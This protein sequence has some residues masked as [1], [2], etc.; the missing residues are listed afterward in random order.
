VSTAHPGLVCGLVCALLCGSSIGCEATDGE[1]ESAVGR[2]RADDEAEANQADPDDEAPS[3][4]ESEEASTDAGDVDPDAEKPASSDAGEGASDEGQCWFE[5]LGDW[6]RCEEWGFPNAIEVP[7]ESPAE[8]AQSCRED[9][10]C[11]AYSEYF[12]QGLPALEGFSDC[13]HHVGSCENP[14]FAVDAKFDGAREYR[15]VCGGEQPPD[16]AAIPSENRGT[17][18]DP[19]SGCVFRAL[20]AFLGCDEQTSAEDA[21]GAETLSECLELCQQ[22]DECTAVKNWWEAPASY[23]ECLLILGPCELFEADGEALYFE[24][25]CG[26]SPVQLASVDAGVDADAGR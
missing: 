12:W 6:V 15:K 10:E 23:A 21:V 25:D 9:E 11:S 24:K 17:V 18:V 5:Y 13:F 16:G 7:A 3:G 1:S 2:A 22:R 26:G 20:D 19:D 4:V 8:C 14:E